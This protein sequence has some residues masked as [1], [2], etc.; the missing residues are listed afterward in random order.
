MLFAF[1]LQLLGLFSLFG[2]QPDLLHLPIVF[3]ELDS[4]Q[5]DLL[6]QLNLLPLLQLPF[7]DSSLRVQR[8]LRVHARF[9]I[10]IHLNYN[11]NGDK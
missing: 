3:L 7:V 5:M 9:L 4:L 2:L 1:K 11:Y 8:I 10:L 6:F